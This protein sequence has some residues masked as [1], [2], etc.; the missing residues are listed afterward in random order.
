MKL[1]CDKIGERSE[2]FRDLVELRQFYSRW[3]GFQR[4]SSQNDEDSNVPA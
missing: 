1:D 2:N 4:Y 3:T